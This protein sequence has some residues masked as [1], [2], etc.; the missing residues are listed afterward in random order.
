MIKEVA[1]IEGYELSD[2]TI[3]FSIIE[4]GLDVNVSMVNAKLPQT[5]MND[6]TNIIAVSLVCLGSVVIGITSYIKKKQK[7][8]N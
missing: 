3:Y 7:K 8:K 4:D 1:T 5:D 2:E 6:Y